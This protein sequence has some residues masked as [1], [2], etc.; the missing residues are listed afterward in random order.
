MQRRAHNFKDLTGNQFGRLKVIKLVRTNKR[1]GR[2]L[3]WLCQ[4]ICGKT[5]RVNG[6][7]L[8]K[9]DTRSC[10]CLLREWL[11]N[12]H[13]DLSGRV[14][15]RL[16][17]VSL[18]KKERPGYIKWHCV[19][20]CGGSAIVSSSH[21]KSGHTK[22]CGCVASETTRTMNRIAKA[23]HGHTRLRS[24]SP[25]YVSWRA[26]MQRCYYPKNI[27]YKN[28]GGANPPVI[29]CDRWRSFENFLA[30]MGPR[31]EGTSLGRFVDFGDYKPGNCYW[32]TDE[33]QAL[34]KKNKRHLLKWAAER[35]AEWKPEMIAA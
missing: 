6:V 7:E 32:A 30:D 1:R 10:G 26:M 14:F 27:S 22:S 17:V 20:S 18:F 19:C 4:C 11:N 21:L 2:G 29:V 28:Y 33:Q 12:H 9:G 23:T 3:L 8:R 16:R 5:V 24:A 35:E 13:E 31:P 34:D 15:G 25:E